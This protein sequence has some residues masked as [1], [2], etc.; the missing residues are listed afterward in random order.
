MENSKSVNLY[1]YT[2]VD[3][4]GKVTYS[5]PFSAIDN[6]SAVRMVAHTLAYAKFYNNLSYS[7]GH[8]YMVG[9]LEYFSSFTVSRPSPDDLCLAAHY[10]DVSFD[11][12]VYQQDFDYFFSILSN[13]IKIKEEK[14]DA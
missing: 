7:L 13:S 8:L 10:E 1:V 4:E 11:Y 12:D 6:D 3:S 14:P 9:F 2:T 5:Y